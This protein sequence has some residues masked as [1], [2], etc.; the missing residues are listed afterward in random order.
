MHLGISLIELGRP[1]EAVPYLET[2]IALDPTSGLAR[3]ALERA[4]SA[5]AR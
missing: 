2:A 3:A 1:A 5:P 4:R